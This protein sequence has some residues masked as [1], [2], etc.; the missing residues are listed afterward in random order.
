[1]GPCP[2]M[3]PPTPGLSHRAQQPAHLDTLNAAAGPLSISVCHSADACVNLQ[4]RGYAWSG[5]GVPIARVDVSA[6]GASWTVARVTAT[7]VR[8]RLRHGHRSLL[9]HVLCMLCMHPWHGAAAPPTAAADHGPV[10]ACWCNPRPPPAVPSMP[11]GHPESRALLCHAVGMLCCSPAG[12]CGP[13]R[14]GR[15]MSLCRR[16]TRRRVRPLVLAAGPG[17]NIVYCCCL[18]RVCSLSCLCAAA[19]RAGCAPFLVSQLV[20]S[21]MHAAGPLRI[22]CKAMDAASNTQARLAAL[23]YPA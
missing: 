15:Q 18:S 19:R 6:D 23:H 7:E 4:V 10:I 5:A 16:R 12:A 21:Y 14:C 8:V 9:G 20:S 22:V 3:S 13:G 2:G 11:A 17:R 1:M